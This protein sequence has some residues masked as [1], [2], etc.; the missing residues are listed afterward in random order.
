M[1]CKECLK[2]PNLFKGAFG[3]KNS[4][5]DDLQTFA[6]VGCIE[7]LLNVCYKKLP[8]GKTRRSLVKKVEKT[9]R[10]IVEYYKGDEDRQKEY[11][12]ALAAIDEIE[13]LK[14]MT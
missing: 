2:C 9:L 5:C 6:T 4:I 7:S 8:M 1:L 11:S 12:R 13:T 3:K 10:L 14:K